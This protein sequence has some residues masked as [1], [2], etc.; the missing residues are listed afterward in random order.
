M[1]LGLMSVLLA[2]HKLQAVYPFPKE[3]VLFH[4]NF[5]AIIH[6]NI[7]DLDKHPEQLFV[8]TANDENAIQVG[9]GSGAVL[10]T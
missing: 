6:K 10:M 5:Q 3:L 1:F 4:V 9:N 8:N 7:F 2:C